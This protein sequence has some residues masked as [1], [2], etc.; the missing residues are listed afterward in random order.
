MTNANDCRLVSTEIVE[1]VLNLPY[2]TTTENHSSHPHGLLH[3]VTLGTPLKGWAVCSIVPRPFFGG[4]RVEV[5]AR[6]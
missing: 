6:D 2:S 5:W 4:G 3:Y 1:V